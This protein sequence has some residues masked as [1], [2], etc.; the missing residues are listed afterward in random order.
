MANTLKLNITE[1]R[2]ELKR[3]LD[4]Q[5]TSR[6]KERIQALYLIK[7]GEF[8]T[9]QDLADALGRNP[10]TVYRWFQKYKQQGLNGLLEVKRG[11]GRE[12]AIPKEVI[13]QLKQRLGE[14]NK[15]KT[16]EVIRIW[17]KEVYDV[18]ASYKVVHDVVKYKLNIK[19]KGFHIDILGE[20]FECD[21]SRNVSQDR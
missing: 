11:Q 1:T 2:E 10:T 12:P 3:I 7:I 6:G 16:Y 14:P 4:R 9:L 17:L 5:T 20:E 18:K 21:R 8:K 13:E 15:F 19:L